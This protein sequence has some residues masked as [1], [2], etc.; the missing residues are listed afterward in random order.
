MRRKAGTTVYYR[1]SDHRIANMLAL[2]GPLSAPAP[3]RDDAPSTPLLPPR[4][5]RVA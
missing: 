1:V 5:G 2:A 4:E 3:S